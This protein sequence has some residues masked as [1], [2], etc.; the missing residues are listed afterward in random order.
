MVLLVTTDPAAFWPP[1][2]LALW[3]TSCSTTSFGRR[4]DTPAGCGGAEAVGMSV[5]PETTN[6]SVRL[7]GLRVA[8]EETVQPAGDCPPGASGGQST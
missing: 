2:T 1:A 5:Q 8:E 7:T 6:Q 4:P 3:E